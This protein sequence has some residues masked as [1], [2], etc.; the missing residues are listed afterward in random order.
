M[1]LQANF[2]TLDKHYPNP[3]GTV[4][5]TA[6]WNQGNRLMT[7]ATRHLVNKNQIDILAVPEFKCNERRTPIEANMCYNQ[8]I[9]LLYSKHTAIYCRLQ[10]I[11]PTIQ[12]H[13]IVHDGRAQFLI[14]KLADT[15]HIF[16]VAYGCQSGIDPNKHTGPANLKREVADMRLELLRKY[17]HA[18]WHLLR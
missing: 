17:P 6:I 11:A 8:G 7:S 3:K 1:L 14:C 13:R 4:I 5:R 16:I 18:E 15:Y 10:T 2:P 9:R 12:E